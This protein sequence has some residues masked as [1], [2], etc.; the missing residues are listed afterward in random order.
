MISSVRTAAVNFKIA[1]AVTLP[2]AWFAILTLKYSLLQS[3]AL[4]IMLSV[5]LAKMDFA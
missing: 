4:L 3:K 5:S 2:D 1:S